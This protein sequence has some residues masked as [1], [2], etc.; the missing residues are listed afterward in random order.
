MNV[1]LSLAFILLLSTGVWIWG[2][3]TFRPRRRAASAV[4]AE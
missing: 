1:V 2:R 3:R 4:P